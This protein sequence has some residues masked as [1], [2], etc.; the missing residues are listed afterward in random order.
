MSAARV[1][2]FNVTE[3][4]AESLL[5]PPPEKEVNEGKALADLGEISTTHEPAQD[6][7]PQ[8]MVIKKAFIEE[9]T[10]AA[11]TFQMEHFFEAEKPKPPK[12]ALGGFLVWPETDAEIAARKKRDEVAREAAHKKALA[13][14]AVHKDARDARIECRHARCALMRRHARRMQAAAHTR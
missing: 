9:S 8:D 10:G 6:R 5:G 7:A 4:A 2:D 13:Q 3:P 11:A 1:V 14:T 12:Q